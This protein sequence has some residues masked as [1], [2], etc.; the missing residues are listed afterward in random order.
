[1]IVMQGDAYYLGIT[2]LNNAGS[3]VTPADIRDVE[4][5]IGPIRKT[6]RNA[7]LVY[8]DN[9]WLFPV[10]QQ[11]SFGLWPKEVKAQVRLVWVNGVVEGKPIYG[12]RID[13]STSKEVL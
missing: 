9:L 4:I 10:S 7:E 3:P 8:S 2:I 5:T 6:Y 11:E 12:I 13:E 1:M